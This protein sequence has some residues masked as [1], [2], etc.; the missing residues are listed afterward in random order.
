MNTRDTALCLQDVRDR[1]IHHHT[2]VAGLA[3][4]G[5]TAERNHDSACRSAGSIDLPE[6]LFDLC[7]IAGTDQASD[8]DAVPDEH[9]RR[10]KLDA[11]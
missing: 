10:P 6:C 1:R 9:Q 4:S 2:A 7:G 5:G 11:E 8:F 3:H